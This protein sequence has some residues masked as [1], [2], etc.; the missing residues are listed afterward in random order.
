[1]WRG[2][3]GAP[4][5]KLLPRS[6]FAI[7]CTVCS[8]L[9]LC[10]LSTGV[11]TLLTV[12]VKWWDL[13]YYHSTSSL[14]W[15]GKWLHKVQTNTELSTLASDWILLYL[16][17]S[18]KVREGPFPLILLWPSLCEKM[19]TYHI[20]PFMSPSSHDMNASPALLTYINSTAGRVSQP[21]EFLN[22][23]LFRRHVIYKC[24]QRWQ[25]SSLLVTGRSIP[26]KLWWADWGYVLL[27]GA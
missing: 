12:S 3:G 27:L 14:C 6:D 24:A 9:H 17:W 25:K 21:K 1:M 22:K 4:R 11:R 10:K 5:R 19:L 18:R 7:T 16:Q 15:P 26:Y 23:P 13:M 8:Y 20:P 2:G